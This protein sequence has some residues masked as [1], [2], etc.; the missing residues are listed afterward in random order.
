MLRIAY[1][2]MLIYFE[3]RSRDLGGEPHLPLPLWASTL[4]LSNVS[5]WPLTY[6]HVIYSNIYNIVYYETKCVFVYFKRHMR[7]KFKKNK[8]KYFQYFRERRYIYLPN[9]KRVK[10]DKYM[11]I[12]IHSMHSIGPTYIVCSIR[13]LKIVLAFDPNS[14]KYL[15]IKWCPLYQLIHAWIDMKQKLIWPLKAKNDCK[16]NGCQLT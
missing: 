3:G 9:K 4:S 1:L 5:P 11:Y 14:T 12:Y 10:W 13:E 7:L 6:V 16:F 8:H 15:Q 2:S